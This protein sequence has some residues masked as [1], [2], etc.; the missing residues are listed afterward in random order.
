[1]AD[2]K[3][4]ERVLAQ[5]L[6][7]RNM[8]ADIEAALTERADVLH[9]SGLIANLAD[10]IVAHFTMEEQGGYF[11]EAMLHSPHLVNRANALMAQHP[12]LCDQASRVCEGPPS[13]GELELWWHETQRRFAEFCEALLEH[14]VREDRLLQEAYIR[15]IGSH[16]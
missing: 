8:L 10:R 16:D 1:M 15:D 6:E 9:V 14:E 13:N 2:L 4:H 5:H 11:T 12:R 7:L 3:A